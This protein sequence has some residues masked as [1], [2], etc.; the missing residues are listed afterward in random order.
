MIYLCF[1]N[2]KIFRIENL[3]G[4]KCQLIKCDVCEENFSKNQEYPLKHLHQKL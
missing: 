2:I 3:K 1:E 4:K